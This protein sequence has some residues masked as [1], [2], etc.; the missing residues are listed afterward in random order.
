MARRNT[1][2]R[3]TSKSH[4]LNMGMVAVREPAAYSGG[5]S[6]PQPL[7]SASRISTTP[8]DDDQLITE[9]FRL[10]SN[11]VSLYRL[12]INMLEMRIHMYDSF[13]LVACME[14]LQKI[15]EELEKVTSTLF[16]ALRRVLPAAEFCSPEQLAHRQQLEVLTTVANDLLGCC[17]SIKVLAICAVSPINFQPLPDGGTRLV[18]VSP[19]GADKM[20]KKLKKSLIDGTVTRHRFY[21]AP[22]SE[23]GY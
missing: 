7:A 5:N 4:W 17:F 14:L 9:T 12:Q 3:Q 1:P 23:G 15:S 6:L 2:E 21:R 22:G 10:S 8:S 20:R 19:D 11:L 18:C 13:E 16:A